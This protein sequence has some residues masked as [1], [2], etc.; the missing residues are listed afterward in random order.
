MVI[1]GLARAV[2]ADIER[3]YEAVNPAQN[4]RIHTFLATSDLHL[5]YKLQISREQC[6][7]QAGRNKH[8]PP[9]SH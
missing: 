6:L 8:P 7:E 4:H 9:P 5:E 3:C 1:C 2:E